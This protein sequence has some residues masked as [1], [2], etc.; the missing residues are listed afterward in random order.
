M[1]YYEVYGRN[2]GDSDS[3]FYKTPKTLIGLCFCFLYFS[4]KYDI[5]TARSRKA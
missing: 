2:I 1:K 4:V 5:V 3:V